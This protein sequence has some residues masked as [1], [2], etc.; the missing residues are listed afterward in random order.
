M[1]GIQTFESPCDVCGGD[2]AVE[3]PAVREYQPDQPVHVCKDCGFVYVRQRRSSDEIARSWSEEI[4]EGTYTARIPAVRARQ[5]YVADF[6]ASTIGIEGKN[7]CDIGGGEGQF[8][9]FVLADADAAN[10]FAIEPSA[11]NCQSMRKKGIDVFEGTIEDFLNDPDAQKQKF[12]IVTIMWTL[13]N[14]SSC[15][16]MIDAAYE[17][18]NPGG[19]LLVATGS[20]I[21]VP[22]KKPLQY[23]LGND[24]WGDTHPFRFSANSLRGLLAGSGFATEHINRYFDTDYLTIVARKTDGTED[25]PRERDD[26][27]VVIDFF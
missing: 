11:K 8:L 2:D 26:Y 24:K 27:L 17:I 4:F 1:T 21:L 20:R 18:L 22:F 9:E 7:L 25:I 6:L 13:E 10:V 3:I 19:H 5:V 23:Y 14:C 15:R 12:D 16:T